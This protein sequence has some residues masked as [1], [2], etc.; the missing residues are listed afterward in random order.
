MEDP[1]KKIPN[2]GLWCSLPP[3]KKK[4]KKTR[5]RFARKHF[6][7]SALPAA[8]TPFH[9]DAASVSARGDAQCVWSHES[10][11][12]SSHE[13]TWQC[14]RKLHCSRLLRASCCASGPTSVFKL[15]CARSASFSPQVARRLYLRARRSARAE[16]RR[17]SAQYT[18]AL[19]GCDFPPRERFDTHD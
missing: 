18:S 14:L 8:E 5:G 4:D 16:L 3:Q 7:P 12:S 15:F 19:Q 10:S 11:I 1:N 6:S 2:F 9:I 13:E 17:C